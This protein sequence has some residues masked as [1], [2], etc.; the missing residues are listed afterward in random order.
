MKKG[1]KIGNVITDEMKAVI[2]NKEL[3]SQQVGDI[4]RSVLY[5]SEFDATADG[6]SKMLA[7]SM[8]RGYLAITL[9]CA[10][11]RRKEL[12]RLN[13]Y[14]NNPKAKCPEWF[15]EYYE[16]NVSF[17]NDAILMISNI[18]HGSNNVSGVITNISDRLDSPPITLVP[19][20]T[21]NPRSKST[22]IIEGSNNVSKHYCPPP[23]NV[24]QYQYQYQYQ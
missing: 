2:R 1:I 17:L 19:Q 13:K 6:M 14:Y 9:A 16:T 12:D 24:I 15:K 8:V 23:N 3:T 5:P 10:E 20:E 21:R 18:I 4:L 22:N 7:S 11:S